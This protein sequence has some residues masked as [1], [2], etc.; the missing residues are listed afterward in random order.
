MSDRARQA[1][2]LLRS[3]R[4]GVLSSH[5][6]KLP[7]YPYG[8]ALP[9]VTDATGRP[10][11]LISHL[12]E[13]THNLEESPRASYLVADHG[14]DVQAAAR[15]T[16]VGDAR[17]LEDSRGIAERYLRFYPEHA[18]YL[19]I[20][21]F[22][23][24]TIEPL[25]VRFIEGFGS[26]HWISAEHYLARSSEIERLEASLLG[27]MNGDHREALLA[28]CKQR[29]GIQPHQVE[30]IGFDCD[31]FD[32]RADA[33]VLRFALSEPVLNAQ[34]ARAALI[35]LAQQCRA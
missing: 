35:A 1:R 11:F 6:A 19:N 12:A 8:S 10:L 30:M 28:Y 3:T 7:G 16:L 14:P 29:F 2:E 27:H 20:G 17:R 34:Q 26:L 24:W 13:H 25:Q 9:H 4:S 31:G 32:L 33:R 23:F 21:G 22:A 15:A 18:R 5:S